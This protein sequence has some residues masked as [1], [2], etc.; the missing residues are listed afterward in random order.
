M[1][2]GPHYPSLGS[3]AGQLVEAGRRPRFLSLC[4]LGSPLGT[5]LVGLVGSAVLQHLGWRMV[6]SL[7][8]ESTAPRD[9]EWIKQRAMN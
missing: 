7:T 3:V 1:F 6:V 5:I 2:Q 8:G 4:F 9:D